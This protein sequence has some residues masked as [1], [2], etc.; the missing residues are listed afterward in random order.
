MKEVQGLRQQLFKKERAE[1]KGEEFE[2]DIISFNP[3]EFVGADKETKQLLKEQAAGL[4]KQFEEQMVDLRERNSE[5][6]QK[7][8]SKSMQVGFQDKFLHFKVAEVEGEAVARLAEV[9]DE[10]AARLEEAVKK[11]KKAFSRALEAKEASISFVAAERVL[12]EVADAFSP[13]FSDDDEDDGVALSSVGVPGVVDAGSKQSWPM[14]QN[15][16]QIG[17]GPKGSSQRRLSRSKLAGRHQRTASMLVPRTEPAPMPVPTMECVS[18]QTELDSA[19]LQQAEAMLQKRAE[20][21]W[22]ELP[23]K[24]AQLDEEQPDRKDLEVPPNSTSLGPGEKHRHRSDSLTAHGDSQVQKSSSL[25]AGIKRALNGT[26]QVASP[27]SARAPGSLMRRPSFHMGSKPAARTASISF[28]VDPAMI[29]EEAKQQEA[30]Y[31][32][33]IAAG[34]ALGRVKGITVPGMLSRHGVGTGSFTSPRANSHSPRASSP[35]ANSPRPRPPINLNPHPGGRPA[36]KHR[37]RDALETVSLDNLE[38]SAKPTQLNNVTA[39]QYLERPVKFSQC[40][41]K[42]IKS[43]SKVPTGLILQLPTPAVGSGSC[44]S[45]GTPASDSELSDSENDGPGRS[46]RIKSD[47]KVFTV[48]VSSSGES[49]SINSPAYATLC[50]LGLSEGS[51]GSDGTASPR[52]RTHE[53]LRCEA[54]YNTS[55]SGSSRPSSRQGLALPALH[56]VQVGDMSD[57]KAPVPPQHVGTRRPLVSATAA[58][59]HTAAETAR[60]LMHTHSLG[61]TDDASVTMRISSK[62]GAASFGPKV[63][64]PSSSPRNC[65]H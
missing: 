8:T 34:L 44:D 38:L 41:E 9:E 6:L 64:G 60:K 22:L 24:G 45:C 27:T 17:T 10:A 59:P 61:I 25:V 29:E 47:A 32:A 39:A 19:L 16:L 43:A 65:I 48:M 30:A 50:R 3:S 23:G 33:S 56:V 28:Q 12:L 37:S 63:N 55:S 54:R 35:A 11:A 52:A 13:R 51:A 18:V 57:A 5:L 26:L 20:N 14:L 46:D 7:V 36:Q 49:A 40:L 53:E 21:A 1:E 42:T 4:Q 58:H 15:V 2:A 31:R 62:A